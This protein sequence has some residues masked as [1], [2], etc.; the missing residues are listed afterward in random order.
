MKPLF[1]VTPSA[2]KD[3]GEF[4]HGYRIIDVKEGW[5]NPR[6]YKPTG[7]YYL[8]YAY[9]CSSGNLHAY[10]SVGRHT[11]I[12]PSGESEIDI[13]HS[14]YFSPYDIIDQNGAVVE[15]TPEEIMI[16]EPND[17][18]LYEVVG[19]DEGTY[20]LNVSSVRDANT[21]TFEANDIPTSPNAVHQYTIDWEALSVGEE[22]VILDIDNDGDGIFEQTVTSDSEFTQE[23]YL[24]N[25]PH[26]L[27]EETKKNLEQAKTGDKID[28]EIDKIIKHI[29]KSLEDYLWIDGSHLN[30]KQGE[31]VFDEEKRAVTK[32]MHLIEKKGKKGKDKKGEKDVPEVVKEACL[33]A[34]DKLIEAD[35]IL[36]SIIYNEALDGAG[37]PKVDK[38]L[39]KC[40][41]EFEK[42]D[43]ELSKEKYDKAIDHYKKAW[44]HAQKAIKHSQKHA[45][46]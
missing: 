36:A 42:V 37:N 24:S 18:Y 38:E 45:K 33:I 8:E 35:D 46:K 30:S 27:K 26:W 23:E 25:I 20:L 40:D 43:K 2:G 28:T 19:T 22:G 9:F 12:S 32:L 14:F 5:A 3:K 4:K 31:K 6:P 11:G 13:P 39:E 10:D 15:T 34:I 16:Y 21:I 7:V 17:D 44:E 29:Q 41:K 1:T